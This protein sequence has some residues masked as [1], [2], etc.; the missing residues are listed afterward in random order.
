MNM[1]ENKK[2]IHIVFQ[3]LNFLCLPVLDG[4]KLLPID[5]LLLLVL[6]KHQGVRGIFPSTSTLA[7]ELNI[8]PTYLKRI[9]NRLDKAGIIGVERKFG[10]RHHYHLLFLSTDRTTTVDRSTTV[11]QSTTVYATGQPQVLNRSTTV[12]TINKEDQ[13]RRSKQRERAQKDRAPLSADFFPTEKTKAIIEEM[14][15]SEEEAEII[16]EDFMDHFLDSDTV[17][18][19][20]NKKVIKWFNNEKREPGFLGSPKSNGNG[21]AKNGSTGSLKIDTVADTY[22]RTEESERTAKEALAKILGN[23]KGV[24]PNGLLGTYTG[25]DRVDKE[26][27]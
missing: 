23:L 16:F 8:S 12:D 15:Y 21:H 18:N 25:N 14:G 1:T 19:A 26:G 22:V 2:D 20:W 27:T 9:V 4:L 17:S 24:K 5:K 13:L 7:K 11:D 3:V 10:T 6:A